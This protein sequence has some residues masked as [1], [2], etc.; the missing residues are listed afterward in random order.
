MRVNE[1]KQL[2]RTIA[3][4]VILLLLS[5]LSIFIWFNKETFKVIIFS[6]SIFWKTYTDK[7]YSIKYPPYYKVNNK[8]ASNII[9]PLSMDFCRNFDFY[10][11][12]K[13]GQEWGGESMNIEICR[14]EIFKRSFSTSRI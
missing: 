1:I 6:D 10:V 11:P 8:D 2:P 12:L 5:I 7:G 4:L 14:L 13:P 3:L 9:N